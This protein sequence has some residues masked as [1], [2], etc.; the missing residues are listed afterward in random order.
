MKKANKSFLNILFVISAF[1]LTIST[2][3]ACNNVQQW[4]H[5]INSKIPQKTYIDMPEEPPT[6]GDI[7]QVISVSGDTVSLGYQS[8]DSN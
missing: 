1:A 8:P 7:L 6:V 4:N 3:A 2:M 5:A